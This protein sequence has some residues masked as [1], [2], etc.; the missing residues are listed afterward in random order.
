MKRLHIVDCPRSG[1]TTLVEMMAS[2]FTM[3]ERGAQEYRLVTSVDPNIDSHRISKV[4]R[5]SAAGE[6]T[7]ATVSTNAGRVGILRL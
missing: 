4:A 3:D 7:I 6:S 5:T 1:T 2:C